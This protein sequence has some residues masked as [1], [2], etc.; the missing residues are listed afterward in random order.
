M[1]VSSPLLLLLCVAAS[2]CYLFHER[3]HPTT[4]AD[5]GSG[6]DAG[7]D[8]ATPPPPPPPPPPLLLGAVEVDETQDET[9]DA[10]DATEVPS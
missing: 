3:P 8:T 10:F 6:T 4:G 9:D 7:A 2:G 1:R 5:A